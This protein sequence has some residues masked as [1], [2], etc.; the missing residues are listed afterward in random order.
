MRVAGD[1]GMGRRMRIRGALSALA[2]ILS[3]ASLA[4]AY[5]DTLTLGVEAG[6]GVVVVPESTLPC[7]GPLI[8]AETSI[9]LTDAITLRAHLAWAWHPSPEPDLHLG[10]FGIE[11]FYLLDIVEIVPFFGIGLDVLGTIVDG[12]FGMEFGFHPILGIDYLVSR[13][14]AIGLDI[15]PHFLFLSVFE[16]GRL[17][18]AYIA[19]NARLSYRFEL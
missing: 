19:V 7:C 2:L 10:L 11:A 14:I 16:D 4:H 13:E 9:G 3:S 8:G 18:P 5:E 12:A 6:L 15:R 1:D 17:E